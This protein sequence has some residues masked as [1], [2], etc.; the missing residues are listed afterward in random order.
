[1]CVQRRFKSVCAS[2]Q[3]NQSLSF[4]HEKNV[5]QWLSK[6][7]LSKTERMWPMEDC[8]DAAYQTLRGCSQSKTA[9]M[10]PIEDCADAAY[11]RLPGFCLSKTARMWPIED[12]ADAT[13][14]IHNF[15]LKVVMWH[16]KLKRMNHRTKC[17][18]ELCPYTPSEL[19][20]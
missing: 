14:R 17:K 7:C 6:E 13:Y 3:T 9:Q 1:M 10:H 5:G 19:W 12:C 2:A 18:H 4:L 15:F 8:A 11:R 20:G 16:I